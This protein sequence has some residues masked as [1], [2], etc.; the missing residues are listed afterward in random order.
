[1][2]VRVVL[3]VLGLGVVLGVGIL[4]QLVGVA[5]IGDH[6]PRGLGEGDLIVGGGGHLR[7]AFGGLV[8][9]EPLPQRLNIRGAL[10][11]GA[12]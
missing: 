6:L 1:L 10:R 4:A 8:V 5:Q 9:E 11:R 2:I 3:A 12:A 7:Q